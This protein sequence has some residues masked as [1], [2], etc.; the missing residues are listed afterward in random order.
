M[1]DDDL[2]LDSHPSTFDSQ[3]NYSN[4]NAFVLKPS[5]QQGITV[6]P[7]VH[8]IYLVSVELQAA[9][10]AFVPYSRAVP[11]A[12]PPLAAAG[13]ADHPALL[14]G[15][16][17]PREN[18]IWLLE[19]VSKTSR[20]NPCRRFVMNTE[21]RVESDLWR[22][23]GKSKMYRLCLAAGPVPAFSGFPACLASFGK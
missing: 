7:T 4:L 11:S 12:V 14:R 3:L 19:M 15:Q 10:P 16:R 8:Y 21:H 9:F 5:R 13:R 1:P 22:D 6:C 20:E 17:D 2:V 18:P 23:Q